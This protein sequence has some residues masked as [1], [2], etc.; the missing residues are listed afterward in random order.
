VE[1]DTN[2]LV[3]GFRAFRK[4]WEEEARKQ[5]RRAI[6]KDRK[7]QSKFLFTNTPRSD[8]NC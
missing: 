7:A 4:G 1:L 3:L 8:T 5:I 6:K 2:A